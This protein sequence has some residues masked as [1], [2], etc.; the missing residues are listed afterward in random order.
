MYNIL[1]GRPW[2][3]DMEAMPSIYHQCVKF[4]YN[5]IEI[6][7][8]RDNTLSINSILMSTHVPLNREANYFDVVLVECKDKFKPIDL[9]MGGYRLNSLTAL[10]ISPRSYGKPS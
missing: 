3:H 7:I 5:G 4:P 9:G 6:Y 10:P 1:L 8:P 2:I